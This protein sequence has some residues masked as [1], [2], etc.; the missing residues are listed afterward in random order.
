[1]AGG[2]KA[3]ELAAGAADAQGSSL[4]AG[5]IVAAICAYACIHAF[6][7]LVDRIGFAPFVA[8][9]LVL[10]GVLFWLFI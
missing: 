7:L 8:Y 1:M 9:R 5:A 3:L 6:L 2:Y 4:A 10:G